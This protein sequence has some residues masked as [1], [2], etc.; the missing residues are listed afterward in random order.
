M[1]LKFNNPA[2]A[3]AFMDEVEMANIEI[4][5]PTKVRLLGPEH[6]VILISDDP[7]I[8][9]TRGVILPVKPRH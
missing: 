5:G 4:E 8:P 1:K 3:M 6:R 7:F 2:D 9:C